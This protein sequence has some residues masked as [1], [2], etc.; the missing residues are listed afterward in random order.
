MNKIK[1]SQIKDNTITQRNLNLTVPVNNN[2]AVTKSY[3]E[4]KSSLQ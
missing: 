3:L 2:D 4:T 1:G